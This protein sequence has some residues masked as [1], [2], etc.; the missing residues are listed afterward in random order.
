MPDH[1]LSGGEQTTI[2]AAIT[3]LYPALAFNSGAT[4]TSADSMQE[5]ISNIDLTSN[6]AKKTFVNDSNVSKAEE[7]ITKTADMVA[8]IYKTANKLN[9]DVIF[10]GLGIELLPNISNTIK[11]T[12]VTFEDLS[13]LV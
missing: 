1:Y 5:F 3:E 13:Q 12:F 6:G 2:N 10:G 8:S 4:V 11:K 7:Y 9:V